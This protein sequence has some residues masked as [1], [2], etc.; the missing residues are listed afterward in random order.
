MKADKVVI[1]DGPRAGKIFP[2]RE[3]ISF[4]PQIAVDRKTGLPKL[5]EADIFWLKRNLKSGKRVRESEEGVRTP[6][7][8]WE[9]IEDWASGD[10]LYDAMEMARD[11]HSGQW[12]DLYKL[13]C[14]SWE[15]WDGDD[16]SGMAS[17][18]A[19]CREKDTGD[20]DFIDWD[21]IIEFLEDGAKLYYEYDYACDGESG[22]RLQESVSNV[23]RDKLGV[24][25][26]FKGGKMRKEQE[27]VLYEPENEVPN[28][29]FIQSDTRMGL[30]KKGSGAVIMSPSTP[31][32]AYTH[33]L[34][35]AIKTG[36]AE[37][38]ELSEEDTAMFEEM[39][40]PD[41]G[42]KPKVKESSPYRGGREPPPWNSK[43]AEELWN[44]VS[45][46]KPSS[47]K[48]RLT[49][50]AKKLVER[51][52]FL[53]SELDRYCSSIFYKGEGDPREK[54]Y[55]AEQQEI[56]ERMKTLGYNLDLYY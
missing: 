36:K 35:M 1:A 5:A 10:G 40:D 45:K 11:W 21:S 19:S 47:E 16:V 34:M 4:P 42:R 27:F 3:S 7:E 31:S 38:M 25:F 56:N 18:A 54:K 41:F 12:S 13:L 8:I 2:I 32:G 43:G 39:F 14:G 50:E 46:S 37:K 33:T 28:L 20:G 52:K 24:S 51:Y 22:G 29:I 17:E 49:P 55:I 53:N 26:I 9:D 48:K 23:K 6:E 15:E 30:Y 44:R